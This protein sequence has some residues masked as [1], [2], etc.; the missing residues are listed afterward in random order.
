[1][2]A[3][4]TPELHH[5]SFGKVVVEGGEVLILQEMVGGGR[6]GISVG[7]EKVEVEHAALLHHLRTVLGSE[8]GRNAEEEEGDDRGRAKVL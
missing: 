6:V 4:F 1:M 7:G 5:P 8:D 2:L 3:P